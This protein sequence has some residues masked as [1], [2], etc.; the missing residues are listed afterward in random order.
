MQTASKDTEINFIQE[1]AGNF[2]RHPLQLNQLF[3]ADAEIIELKRLEA[4]Y[5]VVKTDS[6]QEE[7]RT[8]LY[9]DPLLIGWISVTATLSD[10][11]AVGATPLGMLLSLQLTEACDGNW[12]RSFQDGIIKACSAYAVSILGG[13]T[14]FGPEFSVTTMGVG[15]INKGRPLLRTSMG[16]GNLLYTTGLLGVGNAFAYCHFFHSGI[17]INYRPTARLA[18]S[19]L[20]RRYATACIDTSDGLFPALSFLAHTNKL[21]VR[22]QAPLEQLLDKQTRTLQQSTRIPAWMFLA[23]PHGEYELLFSIPAASKKDFENDAADSGWSPVFIGEMVE[24]DSVQFRSEGMDVDLHP[25][26]I[27]NLFRKAAGDIPRYFEML[28]KQHQ[29]WCS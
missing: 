19:K 15:I 27:P 29:E 10:L 2:P 6:I 18:E 20:I 3:E 8:K 7:I 24:E 5:L 9:E 25:A 17:K 21:G 14:G 4:E 12:V 22:I 11:A 26:V 16:R 1:L 23:G 28:K 13:D